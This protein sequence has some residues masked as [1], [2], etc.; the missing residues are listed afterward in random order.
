[1]H[2]EIKNMMKT[3]CDGTC[4]ERERELVEEHLKECNECKKKLMEM[5]F[6]IEYNP[7]SE[8]IADVHE[9]EKKESGLKNLFGKGSKYTKI[10]MIMAILI[11]AIIFI[12]GINKNSLTNL[13]TGYMK[14]YNKLLYIK[15]DEVW[16]EGGS[17]G[18]D[19][20]KEY[21][22]EVSEKLSKYYIEGNEEYKRSVEALNAYIDY[23]VSRGLG[24]TY[25]YEDEIQVVNIRAMTFTKA[26][27]QVRICQFNQYYEYDLFC[28]R[29]GLEWKI[30]KVVM[31]IPPQM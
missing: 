21:K 10:V 7:E 25:H 13:A 3:Y 8:E 31:S 26:I 17:F 18:N 27:V 23:Q 28:K 30:E 1:M 12:I 20:V 24:N 6:H 14:S 19:K 4:T 16:P 15:E 9:N 5:K 2:N 22:E 11:V 29:K